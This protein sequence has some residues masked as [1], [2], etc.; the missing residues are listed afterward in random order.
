MQTTPKPLILI[1]D[2]TEV[3]IDILVD[4]LDV[5]YDLSVALDG[6]SALESVAD[7]P[8]D[9][10]LLDI[11]MPGM[12]GYEVCRRLKESGDTRGIPVIFVTAKTA[13]EDEIRGFKLG[14]VDYITKPISPPR[15]QERVRAHLQLR[16]AQRRLEAQNASLLEAAR[17]REDVDL[18]MRHDLKTPLSSIIGLPGTLVEKGNLDAEQ[19][20][21]LEAIEASGYRM[22]NMVNLSLDLMKMERGDY[23][24]QPV[25]VNIS[26]LFQK[27]ISETATLAGSRQITVS[28]N[29]GSLPIEN[30]ACFYILGEELLCYSLFAN[31]IKNAIEAAPEASTV[32]V[33]LANG[34]SGSISI[35]NRGAVPEEIR[36]RFFDKYVTSGKASGT[37][38]GTYSARL[39][40]ETQ[41]GR[42]SLETSQ[43]TGTTIT[44]RLPAAEPPQ[45]GSGPDLPVPEPSGQ[46]SAGFPLSDLKI[47][48]VDD[49]PF[50]L[51]V[52]SRLL[53][54]PNLETDT[55]ENGKIAIEKMKA[56]P[57]DIVFMDMEMPVL[58]GMETIVR[59]R[60]LESAGEL[61]GIPIVAIALS[62][63]DDLEIKAQCLAVGFDAY[64][65]KPV[66]RSRLME[67]I[68]KF[69]PETEGDSSSKECAGIEPEKSDAPA[70]EYT[71]VV[72]A[73]LE[74]LIP[75]FLEAKIEDLQNLKTAVENE[76]FERARQVSH[77]L[78]GA[79]NM[80]GFSYLGET[81][82]VMEAVA[83][84][85]EAGPLTTQLKVIDDFLHKMDLRFEEMT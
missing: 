15:V 13:I 59:V 8:P 38:L 11:M 1:V 82:A 62:A 64:L 41:H 6:P 26:T 57:Y 60:K 46:I 53:K 28:V 29:S 30:P 68:L 27:I 65:Q 81:C 50:N 78:K 16:E 2:D 69:F 12:D 36:E 47:L 34:E 85:G 25:P 77:K 84:A 67:S 9:L 70:I 40:T 83:P 24:F 31:L 73:D 66:L 56:A 39:I 75:A 54:A 44:V 20:A 51:Q 19:I 48:L 33:K 21:A 18:I 61:N 80:Y 72:D 35:H 79:F 10:I 4:T 17:L 7:E 43:T 3:N 22:L 23:Q 37:G 45:P 52:L 58:N 49:D 74:D 5:D 14:A 42:I 55:A 71:V 32:T 63:H 76:N